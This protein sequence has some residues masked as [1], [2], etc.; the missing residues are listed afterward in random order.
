[1]IRRPKEGRN[2]R[3]VYFGGPRRPSK[4][5]RLGFTRAAEY[6]FIVPLRKRLKAEGLELEARVYENGVGVARDLSLLRIDVGI[7]PLVALLM[8][9]SLDAPFQIIG[10]AGSGGSSVLES[11]KANSRRPE[12]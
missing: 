1:M 4:K 7:A 12:G 9:H 6:P 11:P 8:M 10:P 5:L 2:A 3:I